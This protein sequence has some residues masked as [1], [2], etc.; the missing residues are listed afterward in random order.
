MADAGHSQKGTRE[1]PAAPPSIASDILLV[2]RERRAEGAP[3]AVPKTV[4]VFEAGLS[5]HGVLTDNA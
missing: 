5:T 1:E 2:V 4:G 3:F